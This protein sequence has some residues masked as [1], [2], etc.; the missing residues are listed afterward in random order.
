MAWAPKLSVF[1]SCWRAS[2]TWPTAATVDL[3][4]FFGALDA[5]GYEGR[6]SVEAYS[7]DIGADSAAALRMLK[8][9]MA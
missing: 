3:A 2:T 6:V 4:S 1:R 5:V 8:G 9:L 7:E